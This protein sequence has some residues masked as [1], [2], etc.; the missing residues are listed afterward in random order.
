MSILKDE[1]AGVERG[2]REGSLRSYLGVLA[3]PALALVT[4]FAL[5]ASDLSSEGRLVASVAVLLGTWWVSEAVP[6]GVTSLVPVAAFPLVGVLEPKDA[7]APYAN[8][9]VFLFLGGF[10]LALALQHTGVHRRLALA[11]VSMTGT[12]PSRVIAGFMVATAVV[13]MFVSNG[14]TT[15][16]MLPIALAVISLVRDRQSSGRSVNAFAVSL[17]IAVAYAATIG[18]LGSIVGAPVNVIVAGYLED[19]AGLS[20]SFLRWMMF[21]VPLAAVLLAVAWLLST[22]VFWRVRFDDEGAIGEAL[23]VQ[24]AELGPMTRD[25]KAALTVFAVAAAGWIVLPIVWEN[26]PITDPMVAV[27]AAVLLFVLPGQGGGRLMTWSATRDLPWDVLLLFGAGFCLS[28]AV[29]ATDLNTWLAALLSGLGGLPT[30]VVILVVVAALAVLT[31]FTSS[32]ATAAA[33]IPVVGGIAASLGFQPA[34]LVV[35]AGFACLS[36]YALPVGTPPNAVVFASGEVST[37]NLLK[38]GVWMNLVSVAAVTAL[39]L[40]LIP[41]VLG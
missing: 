22:K 28:A 23:R 12:S 1:A 2:E 4:F 8:D 15:V 3:G 19:N 37:R 32:V 20:I 35:A 18:S 24:K 36:A 38:A 11:T 40:T 41:A 33:F 7:A 13:T 16:M 31:E 6:L 25:E 17:L 34:Q 9:T 39:M 27:L 21:G 26:A 10:V 14:A 5:A 29:S 30:V